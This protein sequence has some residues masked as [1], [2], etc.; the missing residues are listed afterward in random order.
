MLADRQTDRHTETHTQMCASQY[1]A[2]APAGEVTLYMY[3]RRT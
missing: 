2:T 3:N 1:F